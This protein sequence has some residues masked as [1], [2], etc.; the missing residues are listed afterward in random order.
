MSD[1][2]ETTFNIG[3][4]LPKQDET[5]QS[6]DTSAPV[7]TEREGQLAAAADA[8]QAERSQLGAE[9]LDQEAKKDAALSEA[10]ALAAEQ[11]K[12]QA[13]TEKR[14]EQLQLEQ[15]ARAQEARTHALG[16]LEQARAKAASGKIHDY[17]HGKSTGRRVLAAVDLLVGGIGAGMQNAGAAY[18]GQAGNFQNQAAEAL[19]RTID[20]DF[21]EQ[22]ANLEHD[23][24]NAI[25]AGHALDRV[26]AH[27]KAAALDLQAGKIATKERMLSEARAAMAAKNLPVQEIDR[28]LAL[29]QDK[30]GLKDETAKYLED[31]RH[32]ETPKY[33]TKKAASSRTTFDPLPEG[34]AGQKDMVPYTDPT[35]GK[36][37]GMV[38]RREHRAVTDQDLAITRA[39]GQLKELDDAYSKNGGRAF[40]GKEK[41]DLEAKYANA[42]LGVTAASSAPSTAHTMELEEKSIGGTSG[43]GL[44]IFPGSRSAV[45]EKIKELE[46]A[47]ANLRRSSVQPLPK[48]G[49]QAGKPEGGGK[50]TSMA[51]GSIV[52]SGGKRYKV[53]ADGQSVTEVK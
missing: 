38:N 32:L 9:K 49:G 40:F 25:D 10:D 7:P 16:E 1:T 18:L 11:L 51:P 15:Q 39:L 26:D 31:Q 17:F 33:M 19:N 27:Y 41:Q 50:V 52:S 43:A 45:Q 3:G 14:F 44:S 20:R 8:N 47:R 53:G 46:N 28:R 30:M 21:E 13:E 6:S 48:Q 4:Q 36:V 23:R 34:V 22:K 5:V 37:T 2:G 24:Q 35:T 42:V 29:I 12:A